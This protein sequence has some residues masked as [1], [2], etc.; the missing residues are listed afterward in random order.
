MVWRANQK[1]KL[2]REFLILFLQ[3]MRGH[4]KNIND[5]YKKVS[6]IMSPFFQ[7]D[8]WQKK[9]SRKWKNAWILTP[10]RTNN[11]SQTIKNNHSV[12]KNQSS[13]LFLSKFFLFLIFFF[14]F[15]IYG[16]HAMVILVFPIF[17]LAKFFTIIALNEAWCMSFLWN[18]YQI[19]SIILWHHLFDEA[20]YLDF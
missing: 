7:F 11:E 20:D 14:S 19:K 6:K 8:F 15:S 16:W 3:K 10:K 2:Q 9:K 12:K 1:E 18:S 13:S 17:F 4:I 5:V